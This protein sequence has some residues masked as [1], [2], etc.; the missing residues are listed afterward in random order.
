VWAQIY[1]FI[2]VGLIAPVWS[3]VQLW[4]SPVSRLAAQPAAQKAELVTMDAAKLSVYP[5]SLIMGFIVPT[6]LAGWPDLLG[7]GTRQIVIA[8][9]QFFPFWVALWQFDIM[10]FVSAYDLVPPAAT[11][12]GNPR[13]ANR[14]YAAILALTAATHLTT[15]AYIVFPEQL[16]GLFPGL[17]VSSIT[18]AGALIP[19][20]VSGPVQ[21]KHLAEGVLTLLQYDMYFSTGSLLLWSLYQAYS[22]DNDVSAALS[23][24]VKSIYRTV[25]VG[26]A[27]AALWNIW[28]RDTRARKVAAAVDPK[29]N[30]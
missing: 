26:P 5:F 18:V 2:P 19:G 12:A 24:A 25:L 30:E 16:H 6:A 23:A 20:P 13:Y 3:I 4:K 15:L 27:G 7:F 1:Q 17:D 10:V 14:A 28:D 22:L 11:S 9:W 29:K 21:I 8:L